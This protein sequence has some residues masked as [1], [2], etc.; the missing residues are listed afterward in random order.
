[1]GEPAGSLAGKQVLNTRAVHQAAELDALLSARGALPLAYPC[2]RIE[3][4]L[5]CSALDEVLGEAAAGGFDW[6]VLTSANAVH[7][8]AGRLASLEV[9]PLPAR[10][11]M[12]AIGAG[13][14]Q[15]AKR[16]LGRLPELVP[17]DA[18]A[19]ALLAAF[20]SQAALR[21][22]VP[23]GE[24][25][26]PLLARELAE[27]ACVVALVAYRTLA[28]SGGVDLPALLA[29]GQ[30][31]AVALTSPS[32]V[33]NLATRLGRGEESLRALAAVPAVCIGPLT[34]DAAAQLG[35]PIIEAR[36][37]SLTGLVDA[38]ETFF[39]TGGTK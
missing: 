1:M 37:Q 3:P 22:L 7:V 12:A 24:L 29:T 20:P 8:I 18:R 5:D 23:Q 34:A 17:D 19:E 16:E 10:L 14:A 32:T 2:I 11:H 25:A 28:G 4:P 27:R 39:S 38:L 26:R 33:R 13:T 36:R 31:D 21:V 9:G 35:L 30:V 15:A 6:L